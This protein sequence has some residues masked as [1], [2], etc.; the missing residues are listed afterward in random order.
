[1]KKIFIL[2][3]SCLI[4]S[5]DDEIKI[6]TKEKILSTGDKL[7]ISETIRIKEIN[8]DITILKINNKTI[9]L[10]T[11]TFST[12]GSSIIELSDGRNIDK[13]SK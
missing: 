10:A 4:I 9:V 7:K 3:L 8:T 12:G 5:C 11:R 2:L 6:D 13:I 1:M